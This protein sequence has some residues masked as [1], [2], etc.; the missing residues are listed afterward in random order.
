M[1]YAAGSRGL[2]L[3]FAEEQG[4]SR[5]PCRWAD[6]IHGLPII[7]LLQEWVQFLQGLKLIRFGGVFLRTAQI[8]QYEIDYESKCL[9]RRKKSQH[10]TIFFGLFFCFAF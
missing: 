3:F 6:I 5:P 1:K 10:M 4:G 8:Y 7:T 9:L 2:G